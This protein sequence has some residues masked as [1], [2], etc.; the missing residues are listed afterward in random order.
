MYL[1][2]LF[3]LNC[4]I[5]DLILLEYFGGQCMVTMVI[6]IKFMRPFTLLS[7]ENL[8]EMTSVYIAIFLSCLNENLSEGKQSK[9][10]YN[11]ACILMII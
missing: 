2:I 4:N 6:F 8:S 9:Y 11:E 7:P 10:A 1:F 5:S 3:Y